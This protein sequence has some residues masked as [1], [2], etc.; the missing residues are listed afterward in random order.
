MSR[1]CENCGA[2]IKVCFDCDLYKGKLVEQKVG[3]WIHSYGNVKCSV[4]S[5]VHDCREVGKATHYC[6][7]CGA[8]MEGE[9][10]DF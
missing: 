2:D 4:C 8:K 6:S 10:N 5:S 1:P 3:H 9:E 7:F